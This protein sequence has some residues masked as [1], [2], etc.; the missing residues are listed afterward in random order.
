METKNHFIE[1]LKRDKR[2]KMESYRF[3]NEALI[4]AQNVLKLGKETKPET[5]AEI[6]PVDEKHVTGQD[7]SR[8]VKE[9]A[10]QQYGLMARSV[11]NELGIKKTDDIGRI[12]Y[13][14]IEIGLMKKT[15][16]DKIE[17]F[18]N[19]FDLGAELDRDFAFLKGGEQ[20]K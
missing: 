5:P 16:E 18:Y 11:L 12:V 4:Y 10:L 19:V 17:D 9:Y 15:D 2:Y 8:A 1:L 3:I 20:A 6:E 7:L 14:L 13:N